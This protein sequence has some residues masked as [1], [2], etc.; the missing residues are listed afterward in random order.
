MA[1]GSLTLLLM[2]RQRERVEAEREKAQQL[3]ENALEAMEDGFVM[4]DAED[5]LV[6]SNSRYREFYSASALTWCRE[7]ASRTS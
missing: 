1:L 4:F 2:L 3:L 5:R 6:T 7:R